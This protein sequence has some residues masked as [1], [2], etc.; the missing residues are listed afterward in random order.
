MSD[1][2]RVQ[3][4]ADRFDLVLKQRPHHPSLNISTL[5]YAEI[6]MHGLC[7]R[8]T[9]QPQDYSSLWGHDGGTCSLD[10]TACGN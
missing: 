1:L 7:G 5:G 6:I 8:S 2:K 3:H 9:G 4:A 10:Q